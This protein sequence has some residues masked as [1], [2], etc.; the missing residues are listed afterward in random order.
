MIYTLQM[1]K[2]SQHKIVVEL[3]TI[4]KLLQN[5]IKEIKKI[6]PDPIVK[7]TAEIIRKTTCAVCDLDAVEKR[8][9]SKAG[10]PYHG[11]FCITERTDHIKWL[12]D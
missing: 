8:G 12:E 2:V 11:I 6:E 5:L 1:E 7:P 10:K 4:V 9:I 3:E